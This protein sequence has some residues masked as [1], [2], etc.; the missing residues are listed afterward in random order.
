MTRSG[1]AVSA[2]EFWSGIG[3]VAGFAAWSIVVLAGMV[4]LASAVG[5]WAYVIGPA[6]WL[7]PSLR[8]KRLG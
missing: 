4:F 2:Q 3:I 6:I 5:G 7:A 8:A 1:P